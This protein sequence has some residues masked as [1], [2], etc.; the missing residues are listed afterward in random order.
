MSGA[1]V[2]LL[3]WDEARREFVDE[4][5]SLGLAMR[6]LLV[7]ASPAE[8]VPAAIKVLHPDRIQEGLATL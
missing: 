4:M 3:A 2:I 8:S 5:H 7:T 1:L 6:V